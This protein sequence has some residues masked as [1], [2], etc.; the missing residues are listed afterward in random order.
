MGTLRLP[1]L[2]IS[3]LRGVAI[4]RVAL[5]FS[6]ACGNV[7]FWNGFVSFAGLCAKGGF[8]RMLKGVVGT[9]LMI[10][11]DFLARAERRHSFT[12]FETA[13]L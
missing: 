12:F 10:L 3:L 7:E 5:V 2:L 4:G 13:T 1:Q 6:L 9:L 11:R 8:S